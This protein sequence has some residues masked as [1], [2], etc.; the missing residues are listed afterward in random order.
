[1][2]TNEVIAECYK[3]FHA[4]TNCHQTA[5]GYFELGEYRKA[6]ILTLECRSE[7]AQLAAKLSEL[8]AENHN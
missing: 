7:Y 5:L 6:C 3:L 2:S 4:L 8:D 1:M